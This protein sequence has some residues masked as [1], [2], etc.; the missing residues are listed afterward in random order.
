MGYGKITRKQQEILDYIKEEILTLS[1]VLLPVRRSL[2][3]KI[4]KA[5][6]LFRLIWY[7]PA[8][9]LF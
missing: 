8:I 7:H 2:R 4:S 1:A 9:L 6:S 5:T 3:K